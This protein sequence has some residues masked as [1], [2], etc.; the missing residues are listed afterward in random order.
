MQSA[1]FTGPPMADCSSATPDKHCCR[2]KTNFWVSN[3]RPVDEAN[4]VG[5][6]KY[7]YGYQS[8]TGCMDTCM[9]FGRTG[10]DTQCLPAQP[11][12]NDWL[13][14]GSGVWEYSSLMMLEAYCLCGMKLTAIPFVGR[15]LSETATATAAASSTRWRW[16]N[17]RTPSVDAISG[18][19]FQASDQCV[20][21]S[22]NFL[23]AAVPL[24]NASCALERNKEYTAVGSLREAVQSIQP[25]PAM[26]AKECAGHAGIGSFSH[27]ADTYVCSCLHSADV[28]VTTTSVFHSSGPVCY[29]LAGACP[30]VGGFGKE[31]QYHLMASTDLVTRPYGSSSQS[32]YADCDSRLRTPIF[33][34]NEV[35]D[36]YHVVVES[37]HACADKP[38]PSV[39]PAGVSTASAARADCDADAA[40]NF[41]QMAPAGGTVG[42]SGLVTYRKYATCTSFLATNGREFT[43][44]KKGVFQADANDCCKTARTDAMATHYFHV[45]TSTAAATASVAT[46]FGPGVPFGTGH[47]SEMIFVFDFN[48]DGYDDVV[49]GN[50]IFMSGS[51]YGDGQQPTTSD[52]SSAWHARAHTGRPFATKS[53]MAMDAIVSNSPTTQLGWPSSASLLAGSA[54]A[55]GYDGHDSNGNL[56]TT[57]SDR[58]PSTHPVCIGYDAST[59]SSGTCHSKIPYSAQSVMVAIAYE[60]HDVVLYSIE[61]FPFLN[62]QQPDIVRLKYNSTI[63]TS[64]YGTPTSIRMFVRE[65]NEDVTLTRVGTLVTYA[66]ADDVIY[67]VDMPSPA[68]RLAGRP[69]THGTITPVRAA[70]LSNT[71]VPSMCSDVVPLPT[72]Q[73]FSRTGAP[74]P[75]SPPPHVAGAAND[76]VGP[77]D[78]YSWTHLF[79]IGTERQHPNLFYLEVESA[80]LRAF[81]NSVDEDTV[82]VATYRYYNETNA[83]FVFAVCFANLNTQNHCY[84]FELS[85]SSLD[86]NRMIPDITN[87]DGARSHFF[88][89]A[90]EQ[91]SDIAM[92]DFD[93]DGYVDIITIEEGGYAR[94]YRGSAYTE[95]TM[96]FSF[97]VP[98]TFDARGAQGGAGFAASAS[99]R[100]MQDSAPFSIYPG[101]VHGQERFLRRSKLGIGRVAH[102]RVHFPNH[103]WFSSPGAYSA[104]S[105]TQLPSAS[106]SL[107]R[108]LYKTDADT[109]VR[110]V[111][112]HHVTPGL[113]SGDDSS[114]CAMMCHS[115]GRMGLDSFRLFE[116][117]VVTALDAE[118]RAFYYANGQETE[119]L[120]GP[121]FDSIVAPFP[122]PFPPTDP[123]PPMSPS[124][125]PPSPSPGAPPPSPPFPIIRYALPRTT[126]IAF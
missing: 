9:G 81:P 105:L 108:G 72:K 40:C 25:T 99:G 74:P 85:D 5:D 107:F 94:V 55:A 86:L 80:P 12:C 28:I 45:P 6:E 121:R 29:S 52:L 119:C 17:A 98:E 60:D 41:L 75:P 16:P 43:L 124:P 4:P 42:P 104:P 87:Q 37:V 22:V 79:V 118:D 65:R 47:T 32:P 26:C 69:E 36:A 112:L 88:G 35:R 116:P 51:P 39:A 66:D 62:G 76:F 89:D 97:L 64:D 8:V 1:A 20:A 84:R 15:K 11:E 96:D 63:S 103:P 125:S 13:G 115:Q 113:A 77:T 95:S 19:H 70:A 38:E 49:I 33:P 46:A 78:V 59:A 31:L 57:A 114:S 23:T 82:A 68:D 92:C 34:I 44:Y 117:A 110:F 83:V 48:L 106:V 90:A 61:R 71:P 27:S 50:R 102:A 67:Y 53:I 56:V 18:G 100:R 120:C 126:S 24:P 21:S 73:P 58:C 91:T 10:T 7:W 101:D 2:V 30:T 123:P 3:T 109:D 122:P 111:I 93:R 54:C 14:A